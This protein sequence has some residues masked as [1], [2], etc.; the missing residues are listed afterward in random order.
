MKRYA[1]QDSVH[2]CLGDKY[3]QKKLERSQILEEKHNSLRS[4]EA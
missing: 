2:L 3:Q 4:E 1:A